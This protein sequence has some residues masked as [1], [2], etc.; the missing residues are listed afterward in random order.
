MQEE[1]LPCRYAENCRVCNVTRL[2]EAQMESH[3]HVAEGI[4]GRTFVDIITK[5]CERCSAGI[6]PHMLYSV[7]VRDRPSNLMFID[8]SE[9]TTAT[10]ATR[11]QVLLDGGGI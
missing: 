8:R 10:Q 6:P 4:K 2:N 5:I 7:Q 9:P 1:G 3:H 11:D